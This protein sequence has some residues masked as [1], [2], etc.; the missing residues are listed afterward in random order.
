MTSTSL[1]GAKAV[2]CARGTRRE[3]STSNARDSHLLSVGTFYLFPVRVYFSL[4]GTFI[5]EWQGKGT[6]K[7]D[8]PRPA[9]KNAF[10]CYATLGDDETQKLKSKAVSLGHQSGRKSLPPRAALRSEVRRRP[11]IPSKFLARHIES[12]SAILTHS[13]FPSPAMEGSV[14]L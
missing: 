8:T 12:G 3:G 2:R 6:A 10:F 13:S 9:D 4:Y 7:S 14:R 11:T 5:W 1:K